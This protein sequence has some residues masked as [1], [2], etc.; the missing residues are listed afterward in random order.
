VCEWALGI[1]ITKLRLQ[2]HAPGVETSSSRRAGKTEHARAMDLIGTH[3]GALLAL[4]DE[5]LDCG[6]VRPA[7][8]AALV[9]SPLDRPEDALDPFAKELAKFRLSR[10]EERRA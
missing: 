1:R 7:Q 3:R 5:L 9:H 2:S 4:A 10:L 6:L 8:F